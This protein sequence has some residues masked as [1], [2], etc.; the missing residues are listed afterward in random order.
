[1]EDSPEAAV[2]TGSYTP[3]VTGMYTLDI[4][5]SRTAASETALSNFIDNITVSAADSMLSA[6]GQ[7]LT[8]FY[9]ST[10]I[11]DLDAGPSYANQNYWIWVNYSGCY[12]GCNVSGVNIPLN[13]DVLLDICLG[14]PGIPDPSFVGQLDGSGQAQASFYLKPAMNLTGLTLYFAYVVLPPSGGLPVLAAS[15]PINMT[16]TL[17][18]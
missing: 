6:D 5:N 14:Y 3:S 10:R 2:L 11:L 8:A 17:F 16:I 7:T 18:Y 12:P 1:M 4:Q 9:G 15:N 13:Y